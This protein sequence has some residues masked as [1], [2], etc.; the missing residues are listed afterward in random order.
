M[1]R[2]GAKLSPH[3]NANKDIYRYLQKQLKPCEASDI[4]VE[5]KDCIDGMVAVTNI[6]EFEKKMETKALVKDKKGICQC[7]NNTCK[8]MLRFIQKDH[9]YHDQKMYIISA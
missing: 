8:T 9:Q 1:I 5:A 7:I 6:D 4:W 2:L 3:P